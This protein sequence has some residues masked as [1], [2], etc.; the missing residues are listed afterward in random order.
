MPETEIANIINHFEFLKK[1]VS[2]KI[3]RKKIMKKKS[4]PFFQGAPRSVNIKYPVLLI[5]NFP[6]Q[7][8]SREFEKVNCS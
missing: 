8:E 6:F 3:S 1:P 7:R 2:R 5:S 4:N